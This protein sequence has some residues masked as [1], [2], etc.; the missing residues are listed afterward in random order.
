MN[1][2]FDETVG[3][4]NDRNSGVEPWDDFVVKG[5]V[6]WIDVRAFGA[7]GD[8]ATDDTTAIQA[9]IDSVPTG[10]PGVIFFPPGT[11][12][13]S[14][15]LTIP[16]S[17]IWIVGSGTD[18]TIITCMTNT[19]NGFHFSVGGNGG[20]R[21]LQINAGTTKTA[22]A[23][24]FYDTYGSCFIDRVAIGGHYIGINLDNANVV[25]LSNLLIQFIIAT[26][27]IGIL[28][29]GGI[30]QYI[31]QTFIK[32]VDPSNKCKAAIQ[33]LGTGAM[34][35]DFVSVLFSE[36]GILM[37]PTGT[38][39]VNALFFTNCV[40]DSGTYG[41]RAAPGASARVGFLTSTGC[42]YTSNSVNGIYLEGSGNIE[43]MSF[44]GDKIINNGQHGVNM[45]NGADIFIKGCSILGNSQGSSNTYSGIK[46]AADKNS[47]QIVG[48]RIG[49]TVSFSN[50]QKYAIEIAAGTS[51]KYIIVGN[52]L[53]T[54]A[55]G[56]ISDGGTG[57]NKKI[58][59]NTLDTV[60]GTVYGTNTNDSA[61][62]GYVGEIISD[63][64]TA[65]TNFP[66]SGNYGDLC[67]ITLTA[68]DWDIEGGA[69]CA[70]TGAVTF[71][72]RLG[73]STTSGN[74]ATGLTSGTTLFYS[75]PP[76]SGIKNSLTIPRIRASL[77]G[78]TTYYLKIYSGYSGT[79]PTA[80]GNITARRV[81]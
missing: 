28:I 77:T 69:S 42:S 29:D 64:E 48:N 34:Y 73:I 30:E 43:D 72:W 26:N 23:A 31:T 15:E 19:Q 24:I 50:T 3:Y 37:D 63:D 65:E 60:I 22:G 51:N 39:Q 17:L 46:V 80:T 45:A 81:R 14:A 18:N 32:G 25:R 67:S 2:N 33:V 5:P 57:T 41:M 76:I 10:E 70:F 53:T 1:I 12:T 71:D 20:I 56:S 38:D 49:Q 59:G 35:M 78:S 36:A 44:N 16:R 7:T 6:P 8:G 66:T 9:A 40:F 21:D 68:G 74:S 4:I 54:N 11:F 61:S 52:D 79:A 58:V 27:G 62:S 75:L 55:T 13:I 47:F